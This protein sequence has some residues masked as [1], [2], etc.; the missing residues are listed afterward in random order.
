MYVGRF[1]LRLSRPVFDCLPG[2]SWSLVTGAVS[3]IPMLVSSSNIIYS[4]VVKL[5]EK[6]KSLHQ[7]I[8]TLEVKIKEMT[9][10]AQTMADHKHFLKEELTARSK[11]LEG[12]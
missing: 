1:V 2:F 4:N 3:L 7:D 6:H 5:L 11:G 12:R 8:A 10:T 9:N